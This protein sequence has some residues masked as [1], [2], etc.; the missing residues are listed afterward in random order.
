MRLLLSLDLSCIQSRDVDNT[1][2]MAPTTHSA[3]IHKEEVDI[4]SSDCGLE[5]SQYLPTSPLRRRSVFYADLEPLDRLYAGLS[6]AAN[7][8][9]AAASDREQHQQDHHGAGRSA[10]IS[11]AGKT[12]LHKPLD[13]DTSI[14]P[15]TKTYTKTYIKHKYI[16]VYIG[17]YEQICNK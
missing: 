7:R 6:P 1:A 8:L 15:Y 9:Y 16:Y 14:H 3:I 13:W 2:T 17:L 11:N 4:S 5:H 10:H 12:L